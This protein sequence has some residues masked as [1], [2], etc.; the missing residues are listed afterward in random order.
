[1]TLKSVVRTWARPAA[2]ATLAVTVAAIWRARKAMKAARA[3]SPVVKERTGGDLDLVFLKDFRKLMKVVCCSPL[4]HCVDI[5]AIIVEQGRIY[6]GRAHH[7]ACLPNVFKHL[8]VI[9]GWAYCERNR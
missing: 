7:G 9:L 8:R 1:M 2:A 5:T 3:R 4:A 6:F